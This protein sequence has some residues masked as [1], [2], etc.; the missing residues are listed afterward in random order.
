[1]CWSGRSTWAARRWWF[2]ARSRRACR[3]V[4]QALRQH[5]RAR[6]IGGAADVIAELTE[7]DETTQ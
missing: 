6:L 4:L 3:P 5:R 2:P 1:L 7:P